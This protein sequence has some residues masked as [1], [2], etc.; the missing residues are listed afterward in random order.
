MIKAKIELKYYNLLF[1]KNIII[2]YFVLFIFNKLI[3]INDIK[4]K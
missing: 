2:Y 1:N 4:N 3:K